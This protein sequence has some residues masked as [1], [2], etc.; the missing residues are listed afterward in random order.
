MAIKQFTFSFKLDAKDLFEYIAERNV[1]M[2]ID[3]YGTIPKSSKR[4]KELA[5]PPPMLALPAPQGNRK[6]PTVIQIV[7]AMLAQDT[8]SNTSLALIR[9]TIVGAGFSTKTIYTQMLAMRQRGLAKQV[10]RGFYRITAKGL[11]EVNHG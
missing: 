6:K 9:E 7:L 11:R 10:S 3:V 2:N 1:A 5:A 4:K 8:K